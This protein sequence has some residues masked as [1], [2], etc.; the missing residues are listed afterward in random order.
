MRNQINQNFIIKYVSLYSL[1]KETIT[2][3][4]PLPIPKRNN[5]R[6]MQMRDKNVEKKT[7]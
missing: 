5:N 6:V 2:V 4:Y 1:F 3:T 7:K